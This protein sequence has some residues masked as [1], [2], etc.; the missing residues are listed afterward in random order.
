MGTTEEQKLETQRFQSEIK[1]LI[2]KLGWSE[3]KFADEMYMLKLPDGRDDDEDEMDR[4]Y[5]S[6]KKQLNR[7]TTPS[8]TLSEY[9]RLISQ[10]E[11]VKKAKIV[12]PCFYNEDALRKYKIDCDF[13]L[14]IS[15]T[16]TKLV[17]RN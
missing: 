8:E 10:H 11:E 3:R 1:N 14:E 7:S 13:M 5:E 17:K 2:K 15:K 16:A 12:I 9:L 4:F 6:F